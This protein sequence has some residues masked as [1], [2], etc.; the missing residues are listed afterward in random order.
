MFRIID[1]S[2]DRFFTTVKGNDRQN[3]S[4]MGTSNMPQYVLGSESDG[5][6]PARFSSK[7]S[8]SLAIMAD[9]KDIQDRLIIEEC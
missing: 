2:T 1:S 4:R 9:F 8:A 7:K 3:H 5:D 6:R